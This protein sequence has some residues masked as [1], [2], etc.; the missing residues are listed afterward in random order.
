VDYINTD[1][2]AALET[3]LL[4]SDPRSTKPHIYWTGSTGE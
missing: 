1:N 2:L 3:F 4:A